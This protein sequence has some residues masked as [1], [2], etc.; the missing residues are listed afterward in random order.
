MMTH[1]LKIEQ[2]PGNS[3]W[4]KKLNHYSSIL[5]KYL[6]RDELKTVDQ[7]K[8]S[9]MLDQNYDSSLRKL[10]S[11]Y[12]SISKTL[13]ELV[14]DGFAKKIPGKALARALAGV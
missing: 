12:S 8:I 10:S 14:A 7:V 6:S 11:D 9:L 5:Y 1:Y 13:E 4:D 3:L 2:Y